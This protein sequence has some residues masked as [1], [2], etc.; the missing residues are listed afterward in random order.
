MSTALCQITMRE[1]AGLYRRHEPVKVGIPFP[2]NLLRDPG[3]LVLTAPG[4]TRLVFQSKTLE[5]WLDRSVK[6]AVLSFLAELGPHAETVL[7]LGFSEKAQDSPSTFT[8]AISINEGDGR[9]V[10][11]TGVTSFVVSG[12]GRLLDSV[13][14]GGIGL[15]GF[16]QGGSIT[17]KDSNGTAVE[18][19]TSRPRLEENGL[20]HCFVLNKGQ[21]RHQG[22][23][24]LANFTL[25][26]A[27]WASRSAVQVDFTLH[28]PRAARHPG[29]LWDLGDKELISFK[30]LA[31]QIGLAGKDRRVAWQAELS[32]AKCAGQY[33]QLVLQC[34]FHAPL[35][36][37]KTAV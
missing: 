16:D 12:S 11:D 28:N 22:G 2:R 9:L 21:F 25:R 31:L 18:V 7:Q 33:D 17:L 34:A 13:R 10:I 19:Q 23:K 20:L 3:Q 15:P 29:G 1:S 24:V 37:V 4:E 5:S 30:E 14:F 27:F 36:K 26:Y 32:G 35:Q 6:W 8:E